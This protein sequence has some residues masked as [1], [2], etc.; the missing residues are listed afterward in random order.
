MN[1]KVC[2]HCKTEKD[3]SRFTKDK[4]SMDGLSIRCRDCRKKYHDLNKN[5]DNYNNRM[6]KIKNKEKIIKYNIK[7]RKLNREL[8]NKRN[9]NYRLITSYDKNRYRLNKHK[10]LERHKQYVKKR[11]KIDSGFKINRLL[12]GRIKDVIKRES[13]SAHSIELL[14]CSID[15]LKQHLQQTA[16]NNGYLEFDI[17]NYSGHQYHIDHIIPCCAFNLKCGYHQ[18]LCFN[19]SNMQILSAKDNDIK[20]KKYAIKT[21]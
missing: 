14:G 8:I 21:K 1:T 13:K 6:Y 19:W 11:Y 10:E 7:Y 9:A 2:C 16:I 20:G 4:S 17:N 12:R 5:R 18:R 3:I 15:F